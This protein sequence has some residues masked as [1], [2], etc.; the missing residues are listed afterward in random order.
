MANLY[1]TGGQQRNRHALLESDKY[2]YKYHKGLILE[3]DSETGQAECRAEYVSPPSVRA[4]V[5]PAIL[6]K[7][8]TLEGDQLYV[9]TQTEA[10]VYSVPDLAL[11]AYVSLPC[12]ND[13]HHVRPSHDGHLLVASS[14]LDMVLEVT[15][16]GEILH[17][18]NTLG[19]DP[20]AR[21]FKEIDY[22]RVITQRPHRSH[23]NHLFYIGD[24]LWVTR[25]EQRDALCLS[26][27]S[28]RIEIGLQRVHDG[29]VHGD[30]VY[31]TTV[32]GYI[33]IAS[34]TTLRVE[35]VIDLNAVAP[36]DTVL[37]WCRGLLIEDGLA[38]VGF[39]RL[40]LTKL[41][42]NVSWVRRGFRRHLP[43]RIACYDL[44]RRTCLAE[45]DLQSQ[46]LDAVFS[47]IPTPTTPALREALPLVAQTA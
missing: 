36:P 41:R 20:W 11:S 1:V 22:R 8:G 5:N 18:W 32:N 46:G 12:F 39:S 34:A 21:F 35:E 4:E 27:P 37:G 9:G 3:V 28:K 29:H 15:L 6:F 30:H 23:P 17:T 13:V 10:I 47:I 43:T 2:W 33:I 25:F 42:E 44:R 40:R 19:E 7:C 14:G 45:I 31:F 38:W 16:E 26:D 24:E